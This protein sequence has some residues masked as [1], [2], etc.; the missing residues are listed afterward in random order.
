MNK[1]IL[2]LLSLLLSLQV[3]P[4]SVVHKL[5]IAVTLKQNGDAHIHEIWDIVMGDD[6]KT[7]W[8]VAHYNMGDREIC[9]LQV[10]DN[11]KRLTTLEDEWDV[12]AEKEDKMGKCGLREEEGG[13][14]ICWG[15]PTLDRHVYSVDY[16]IKGLVLSYS[17]KDGFGYWFADLNDNDPIKAFR[18]SI[19]APTPLSKANCQVMGFGFNAPVKVANGIAF[20]SSSSQIDKIGLLMSFNKGLF[21]PTLEG[22][23]SIAKLKKKAMKGTDFG[24]GSEGEPTPLFVWILLGGTIVVV[25]PFIIIELVKLHRKRKEARQLP[26][27]KDVSPSWSLMKAVKTLDEYNWFES[28][29]LIGA[30]IF[31]LISQKKLTIVDQDKPGKKGEKELALQIVPESV[32]K[33]AGEKGSDDYL[34]TYLLYLMECASGFNR[35]LTPDKFERWTEDHEE[36]VNDFKNALDLDNYEETLS[37][38]DERHLLGLRNYLIDLCKIDGMPFNDNNMGDEMM[39]YAQLFGLTEKLS[40]MIKTISPEQ[41]KMSVF[42]Q[43]FDRLYRVSDDFMYCFVSA[44]STN[45]DSSSSGGGGVF[46][47]GGGG[48]G[49]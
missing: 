9:N 33:D 44:F 23:G 16:D 14:E 4:Q 29:N 32:N 30:M 1:T 8:Y 7:E 36:E 17:D 22:D 46:S 5:D 43:D 28:E 21:H 34:C 15:V 49:R 37:Q 40:K 10:T 19:K 11:G 20:A 18:L 2:L 24:G 41:L 13:Y 47:G 6:V 12:D 35:V 48:G 3:F 39:V 31:R 38:E 25:I 26:Y 42:A 27:F 45:S